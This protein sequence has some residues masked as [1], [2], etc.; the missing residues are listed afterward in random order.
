MITAIAVLISALAAG[1]MVAKNRGWIKFG[2][3][4]Q[5]PPLAP[6]VCSEHT[7]LITEISLLKAGQEQLTTHI[8]GIQTSQTEIHSLLRDY[9]GKVERL[10]GY[11]MKSNGVNLG[12][13]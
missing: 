9:H 5:P 3:L 4:K 13:T 10:I 11:T 12:G 8:A 7:W 1:T 2:K 6:I